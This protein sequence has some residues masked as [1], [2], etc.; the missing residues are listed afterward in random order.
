MEAPCT[1]VPI[2]IGEALMG[3]EIKVR[4]YGSASIDRI[5]VNIWMEILM[6]KLSLCEKVVS[7]LPECFMGLYTLTYREYFP[8]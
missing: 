1:V 3:A 2:P 6:S 5:K 7:P 8:Y 4:K